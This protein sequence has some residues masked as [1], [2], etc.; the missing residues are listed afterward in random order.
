MPCV[1]VAVS[2]S[3]NLMNRSQICTN[4]K[5]K[6]KQTEAAAANKTASHNNVIRVNVTSDYR[7]YTEQ[8]KGSECEK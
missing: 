6:Q 7:H 3:N 2:L 4:D 5:K 8:T 1:T